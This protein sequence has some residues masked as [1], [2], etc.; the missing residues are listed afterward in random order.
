MAIVGRA[1]YGIGAESQNIW[2]ATVIS[3]WFQ[4]EDLSMATAILGIFGKIGSFLANLVTPYTYEAWG[5]Q[6]AGSFWIAMMINSFSMVIAIVFNL[7]EKKNS[8]R[9]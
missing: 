7:I 3:V 1:I 2:L 6:I 4:H 5:Q 8:K 9:R